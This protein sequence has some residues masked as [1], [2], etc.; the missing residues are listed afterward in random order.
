MAISVTF[1]YLSIHYSLGY[2]VDLTLL[3]IAIVFPLVFNIRGAF[4]RREKALE[5][6]SRFRS[7]L[8]TMQFYVQM[9][10][11]LDEENKTR[12]EQALRRISDEAMICL[13]SGLADTQ[14]VDDA[15]N[16]LH[17][18]VLDIEENMSTRV[19][20]RIFRFMNRLQEGF[21]NVFAIN[22]HRTPQSLK[23]YCLVFIYIFPLIY[24]PNIVYNIGASEN[25]WIVYFIVVITEFILISL[26]NIQDQLEYP[27]DE[28]GMDDIKLDN[29]RPDR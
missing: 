22:T 17:S 2:N 29:F 23:A 4:R 26:Y 8:R 24:A 12:V 5:H 25:E 16:Q 20:D 13:K 7:A 14:K 10:S 18:T 11:D 27:F 28:Y 21:E 19:K 6:L 3:S 9:S 15:I 1:T